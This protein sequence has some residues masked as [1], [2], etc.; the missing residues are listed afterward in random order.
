MILGFGN[1]VVSS[2]A[3]DI[4]ASQTAIPVMPGDGALFSNILTSDFNNNSTTLRNY[5]KITLTDSG[6]TA[7]EICH[8]TAV[9]GDT[10]TVIRG[11]EGTPAKGWS[12]KDVIAN[13][14][15]RG[16]ENAFPQIAHIQSGFYTSGIAGGSAN[17]LTLELP[18]TFFLNNSVD[19]VLKTPIV[20]YPSQ[21]NTGASTL[22]LTMGGIVLG[23]FPL[24]KGNRAQLSANDILQDVALVC[25]MDNTKAFF[26]VANPGAIYAGLGT[27]AF[28]DITTSALDVTPDRVLKVGDLGMS[29]LY[30][31]AGI[32]IDFSTYV[33]VS[34]STQIIDY[35]MSTN[36]PE[37]WPRQAATISVYCRHTSTSPEP[38]SQSVLLDLYPYGAYGNSPS[39]LASK[40]ANVWTFAK[41]YTSLNKPIAID[42]D[43]VYQSPASLTVDLDTLDGTKSGRYYQ[44]S[45]ANAT[46]AFHYPVGHAGTLDVYKNGA[47]SGAGCVQEYRT[48]NTY[49]LFR[50]WYN[51]QSGGEWA[52]SAWIEEYNT[53][54]PPPSVDLSPYMKTIDA[55]AKFVQG[56]QL[57][58]QINYTPSGNEISWT[59]DAPTGCVF[60]GIVVQDVGEHSADN[61]GGVHVKP[62]QKNINGTW[63]TISG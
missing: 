49:K 51:I 58:A 44:G 60:T 45:N 59:Y 35:T 31:P 25:L 12:L 24:Y 17:A 19:W 56:I 50:R 23:T 55:N 11:Q 18:T 53:A 33:W 30:L 1:N 8:L 61:I 2:L 43:A 42:V 13:Y 9:S 22:Q 14:A 63:T 15:T 3:S 32:G 10:L 41:N 48:Y 5:A 52:W 36:V 47:T 4:T 26:N 27:A 39:F 28:C 29:Q 62:I 37:G 57:G 38:E 20:V 21:N 54:N 6:E 40:S 7:F 46:T 16:S 34:K